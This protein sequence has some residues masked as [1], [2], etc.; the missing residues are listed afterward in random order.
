MVTRPVAAQPTVRSSWSFLGLWQS[1][2]RFVYDEAKNIGSQ[3]VA[4]PSAAREPHCSA[5]KPIAQQGKDDLAGGSST[6]HM[7][8][9][10]NHASFS[11]EMASGLP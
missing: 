3:L 9:A 7:S 8:T 6:K 1:R 10:Q 11:E 4:D 2:P 5:E